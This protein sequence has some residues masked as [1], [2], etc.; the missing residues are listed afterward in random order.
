MKRRA[1]I[2]LLSGAA[3]AWPLAALKAERR[4]GPHDGLMGRNLRAEIRPAFTFNERRGGATL[5][6]S[7]V[8]TALQGHLPA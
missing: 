5:S 2:T 4:V 1:F 8:E 6:R 7:Q 3:A